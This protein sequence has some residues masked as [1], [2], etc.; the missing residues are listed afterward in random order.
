MYRLL[1][2]CDTKV[3]ELQGEATGIDTETPRVGYLK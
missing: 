2:L 1:V 3:P